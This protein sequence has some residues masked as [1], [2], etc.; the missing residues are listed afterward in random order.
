MAPLSRS[1][2]EQKSSGI[3]QAAVTPPAI[4]LPKGGGAIRGIGEKFAANPV[5]GTASMSVPIATSPGRSGFGPQLSLAYDSGAGNGPFG[6]GWNLSLPSI[7]RKTDRGLPRYFDGADSD[8]FILSG[9]E[10]LVPEFKKENGTWVMKD[11]EH[12]LADD[13]RTVD[14][15]AYRVRRYRPRIEGLFARVERWTRTDD[16]SD[17][18]WRSISKDNITTWYG[19][20][21]ESRISDPADTRR[22]F[23]WLICES[24]DDRGSV[25]TYRYKGEDSS[26]IVLSRAH[27][28]NRSDDTRSTNRYLKRIRYGNHK[29]H[30][31][32][33]S[34]A[35]P[36]PEPPGLNDI[37]A[38]GNW[39]FEVV[40][41][42]GEHD[43]HDP[44]PAE[45]NSWPKR[46]DPFSTYRAGF[47]VRTY[48]LCQ[49]VL[50]FHH[51]PE[52]VDVGAGCLVRSTDFHYSYEE[53]AAH[54]RNP[55][56]SFL[57]SVSQCGYKRRPTG[58]GYLKRFPPPIEFSYSEAS[59]QERMHD[60]DARSLENLPY[61]LD[62]SA[63]Q[64][65]DLDSEGASG[66]L[67]EQ[68]DGW[69]YKR[70]LSANNQVREGDRERT[71]ARFGAA[72]VVARKPAQGVA[73]GA[74]FLDLA[75]DGQV[76]LVQM[77]GSV[78]GF[79]ERT[80]DADWSLFQPFTSSPDLNTRDPHLR[81][82]DLT[83]D[84]HADILITEGEVLT[85]YPSL[86]EQGFGP[87][88]RVNLPSDDEK[89]P[90]VVFADGLESIYLADL[91]GDGLSDLVRIRNGEICY[92]PNLGYGRFGAKV[93]MDDAPHFDSADQFD[94]KRI[95]LADIDGTGTTDVIYVHRDG[96][97]VYFNQSGN[98]WSAPQT[99]G[100]FPRVNDLVSIVAIDLLGNGTACLVWSSPLPA[101]APRHMRYVDLMGGQKPHLLVKAVNNLGAETV[102]EYAP[103]TKFYLQDEREGKPWITRLP[104]PVHVV[105]RV[106]TYD[107]VSRSRFVSRYAYHHGYFD[108]EEREFRGFGM[109]EQ[110]DKEQFAAL[111]AEGNLPATNIDAASHVP[112]VH[113]RSWFHTGVHEDKGHISR[114]FEDEYYREPGLNEQELAALLL[115]D[116]ALPPGLTPGEEREACRA[117]KGMMLRQEVYADDA[118]AG[119]GDAI[120]KR[121][122]TPYTVLEQNFTIRAV[123]PRG[124]NRHAVFFTHAREAITCHYER[125]PAD[126]RVAH[127]LTLEV[128][129]FGNVV[130]E[131]AIGYG[132]RKG[133][134]P[135]QGAD[136]EKQERP[137]ITY[138][139]HDFTNVVDDVVIYPDAFR[140]PLP[141]ETRTYELTGFEPLNTAVRFSFTEWTDNGFALLAFAPEIS[142]EETAIFTTTQKRL[143]ERV[144]TLYR[145]DDLTALLPFKKVEPRALPGETYTLA[146]TPG[147]LN[148]VFVSTDAAV[149]PEL[150]A[151]LEDPG[152][153]GYVHSQGDA[154]W[155]IPSGRA[156][157]SPGAGDSAA[158]ELSHA[159]EHFFLP[160]RFEDPFGNAATVTYDGYK[161]FPAQTKDALENTMT[162][163]YDYRVLHPRLVTDPN[164][165][166]SEVAFDAL[167]MVV[168][169]AVIG[170]AGEGDTLEDFVADLDVSILLDH[171]GEPLI[172]A[173][174]VLQGASTRLL[175]DL[176]AY[177]RT[178]NDPQPQPAVV[179]TL[180]RETHVSDLAPGE[181]GR[182]QHSFSYSDGFGREIQTKIQAEPGPL[183]ESGPVVDPRWVGSGW[184]VF[185]NKG[186]PVR[187][188][189]P[190]F[191]P[192]HRFE[193][194]HAVGVSP[195]LFYDPLAR[196]VATLHPNHTWQK[197]VFDA[198]R[199]ESWDVNDTVL[200]ADPGSDVDVG[201]FFTRLP[202]ASYLP[203]WHAHRIGGGPGA[204]EQDAA[205]KAAAHHATPAVVYLDSLGRPFLAVADNGPAGK[206]ETRTDL[207]IEGNQRSVI[208][209]LG[210]V[211]MRYDYN[212]LGTAL[213]SASM[214]AGD[215]WTL[216]DV[217][218]QP[219]V[220]WDSR[221]HRLR[222]SYDALRRP[223]EVWLRQNADPELLVQ[224]TVYGETKGDTLNHRTRVFQVSD[225]A[226]IVTSEAYDFKG[227]LT[228]SSR[229]LAAE[230]KAVLDWAGSVALEADVYT[231]STVFD[232]L[233]RATALKTPDHSVIRPTYNE[234]NLLERMEVNLQGSATPTTFVQDVDYNERGQ[235]TLIEYGNGVTTAYEYDDA[236]FRLTRLHT[237]RGAESLQDLRYAYDPAGN[238]TAIEDGAQQAIFFDNTVVTANAAYTYDAIYRLI[239]ATGREH[240][241]QAGSPQTTWNDAFRTRLAHP[242]DGQ[243]M[244][245][246]SEQYGYDA[247]GNILNVVHTGN[248][249]W[250][251][252]YSYNEPSLLEA[253]KSN[254]RLSATDVGGTPEGDFAYDTHGSMTQMPHLPLMQWD[255]LDRLTASSQQ[256]V[257]GGTPE[258]TYYVYDAAGQRVRKVTERAA[259]AGAVPTRKGERIYLGGFEVYRQYDG[260]GTMTLQRESLH[261]VDGETR[262]ALVETR[263][264]GT[265]GSAKQLT[266]YQLGNHL[267][268]AVLEV[269]EQAQ[270]ISYEEYYPYG[271]TSF[272]AGRSVAKV[273]LKQYRYTGK[274]RDEETGLSYHGARYYA[275]WLGRWTS[276]DPAGLV[277]GSAMYSY[278]G[279]SPTNLIDSSGHQAEK[280]QV[281]ELVANI[282]HTQDEVTRLQQILSR[283]G[284]S[285]QYREDIEAQITEAKGVLGALGKEA[286]AFLIDASKAAQKEQ[287]R[288]DEEIA[289]KATVDLPGPVRSDL[290]FIEKGWERVPV[291]EEQLRSLE[292]VKGLPTGSLTGLVHQ[293]ETE[294]TTEDV[295]EYETVQAERAR[296]R[297]QDSDRIKI[298]TAL[299]SYPGWTTPSQ[300]ASGQVLPPAFFVMRAASYPSGVAIP[301]G[302]WSYAERAAI[303]EAAAIKDVRLSQGSRPSEA[304]GEAGSH[305]HNRLGAAGSQEGVDFRGISTHVEIYTTSSEGPQLTRARARKVNQVRGY[306]GREPFPHVL[307]E[308]DINQ[309]V[310]TII[311]RGSGRQIR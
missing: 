303:G 188:Y 300:A 295:S 124:A 259:A 96:V 213:R 166:R 67:T 136:K 50:M 195:V 16:P 233:N 38:S 100:V 60:V 156:F 70:N 292:V 27:E 230:Y 117:L 154:G 47:E 98:G 173:H 148:Q 106:E 7:S 45:T 185:N 170:K 54:A 249:G 241:G 196:V 227:N 229:Q 121:A 135:L 12:V 61:G 234:A 89:G 267:G 11:G 33:L 56:Y 52:D 155:W 114:R 152:A 101:D 80:D 18:F 222:Y 305:A 309:R 3:P 23:S 15:V 32:K 126:P 232:A 79:Y 22:I 245:A 281:E 180:V 242:H 215:R 111:T 224:R 216:Q 83:G 167:G 90:R 77:T 189:E 123:Q 84:G 130:K 74:Q 68:A 87:A 41:D 8:V 289:K 239:H 225:G 169:S 24:H 150:A 255:Y 107:H 268:S 204:A 29:P 302:R 179:Y 115:P 218:G 73:A 254:N 72:E 228:Q 58:E 177:D 149:L 64:W 118:P 144:R 257:E 247:V 95:R 128:D 97:R 48:R 301:M 120:V 10:D 291:T 283:G 159:R 163:G 30:F 310:R 69:Y 264:L 244:R 139:E 288:A 133:Q 298:E 183:D 212:M 55:I 127:A 304:G 284:H 190:F 221:G 125:N 172:A 307:M 158:Q 186:K 175:Y 191:S 161:L 200:S 145:P 140:T 153:G 35:D 40:L 237:L 274:E 282:R 51:F 157:Y 108:G 174:D 207:D 223:A 4:S 63:Y 76:D 26:G 28:R 243:A 275:P 219:L 253:G 113:T 116:T 165:N 220:G 261:I 202:E 49:R 266:R 43:N 201:E 85:W 270:I 231:Q 99:L 36:W 102:V 290:V 13:P 137:L 184:T 104:F 238:I 287:R 251:R 62:G 193:F 198:W 262:I 297:L 260:A 66:L 19:R 197:V 21:L 199:Q 112:P 6:L 37:D 285:R 286:G 294:P 2:G 277:D 142:Y 269:D 110:W 209:A 119:A 203:T 164:G 160:S 308:Y 278:G 181:Q 53:D 162:A 192:T 187:Q 293:E 75:G 42:Y 205:M 279:N 39:L 206:Y 129:P 78:R 178:K 57:L 214:E 71:A 182:M 146:L 217:A 65:T 34:E 25:V 248:G 14:G 236:T 147:L 134:S 226:G 299:A 211:V 31:P 93:T 5:T 273:S 88:L 210:R 91:S 138:T 81:F 59:I 143:V 17:V 105:E 263:L 171:I 256:V 194:A 250:T 44:K 132:R 280:K 235:R 168:G 103:S 151:I 258:M 46:D 246:Y 86:A 240:I 311:Y 208:D 94:Q 20:T 271:S 141:A 92:W 1:A 296:G 272:Q 82:V 9:A 122:R 265:D 176:S 109:V 131:V 306:V 276:A 252:T